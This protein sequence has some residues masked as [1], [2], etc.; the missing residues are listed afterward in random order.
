MDGLLCLHHLMRSHRRGI[1]SVSKFP[2][3]DMVLRYLIG[4][5]L[6]VS[7][8][9]F[10]LTNEQ[11]HLTEHRQPHDLAFDKISQWQWPHLQ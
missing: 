1:P 7:D 11:V 9:I 2:E 5:V 6:Q 3:W 4:L 10:I 8:A